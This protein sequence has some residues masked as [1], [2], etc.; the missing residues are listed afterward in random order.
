MYM[1]FHVNSGIYLLAY[2]TSADTVVSL[3]LFFGKGT[4]VITIW[5]LKQSVKVVHIFASQNYV[6]YQVMSNTEIV[7]VR[8][9][10]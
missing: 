10:A 8:L 2:A 9:F 4:T 5:N 6:K 1:L 7:Q 3:T